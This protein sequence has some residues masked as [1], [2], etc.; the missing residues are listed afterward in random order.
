[1]QEKM[2]KNLISFF[3]FSLVFAPLA[4]RSSS[5]PLHSSAKKMLCEKLQAAKEM[6]SGQNETEDARTKGKLCKGKESEGRR[7]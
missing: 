2:W 3:L 4:L 5:S 6:A 7:I 1:M